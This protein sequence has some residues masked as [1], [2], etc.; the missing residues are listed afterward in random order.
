MPE[1]I[2]ACRERLEDLTGALAG[3]ELAV[4]EYDD[5]AVEAALL[6][7]YEAALSM[8]CGANRPGTP[9]FALR[10]VRMR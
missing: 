7:G 3:D 10:R 9:V 8:D 1:R 4:G 2:H 6:A 5:V